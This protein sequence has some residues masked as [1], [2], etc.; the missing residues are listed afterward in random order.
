M[1]KAKTDA[2]QAQV[3]NDL[4]KLGF[5]VWLT[6]R[7]GR[8]GPDMVVTAYS[9]RTQRVEVLLVELKN[10]KAKLNKREEK[11]HAEYPSDGPLLVARS[12]EDVLRWYGRINDTR[13]V[14]R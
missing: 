11:F 5:H 9:E 13:L 3:A 2:N 10:G 1:L 6:H 4:N 8:G 12:A 14:A 7:I